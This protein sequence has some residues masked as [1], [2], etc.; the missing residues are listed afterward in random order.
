MA[1]LGGNNAKILRTNR[2]P[3]RRTRRCCSTTVVLRFSGAAPERAPSPY[4]DVIDCV[5]VTDHSDEGSDRV[6]RHP[7]TS[8][9]RAQ[10]WRDPNARPDSLPRWNEVGRSLGA[11]LDFRR[12]PGADSISE[13]GRG[14]GVFRSGAARRWRDRSDKQDLALARSQG[15][16][17]VASGLSRLQASAC[18]RSISSAPS[19][20]RART[21]LSRP[22][23]SAS[24]RGPGRWESVVG[25]V[26]APQKPRRTSSRGE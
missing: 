14:R 12:Q 5:A 2:L 19:Y 22:S 11:L 10:P 1:I 25:R 6:R 7:S 23:T 24:R 17:A 8:P 3:T 21:F 9:D 13:P 20:W 18:S 15:D 26:T 16:N 4:R